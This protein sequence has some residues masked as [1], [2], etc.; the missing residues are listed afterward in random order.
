M[1]SNPN[2]PWVDPNGHALAFLKKYQPKEKNAA[3]GQR[4]P[5]DR[6]MPSQEVVHIPEVLPPAAAL[7]SVEVPEFSVAPPKI[8]MPTQ[9]LPDDLAQLEHQLRQ[10]A[11]TLNFDLPEGRLDK[12]FG[13]LNHRLEVKIERAHLTEEFQA[14][15]LRRIR[16]AA[17]EA[18]AIDQVRFKHF[19]DLLVCWRTAAEEH[20][21]A[22]YAKRTIERQQ[23]IEDAKARVEIAECE[24]RIRD[25]QREPLPPP[26]PPPPPSPVDEA[27]QKRQAAQQA[28]KHEYDVA[29]DELEEQAEFRGEKTNR[30]VHEILKVFGNPSMRKAA[31][32]A[33]ILELI[34]VFQ[35][36]ESVLP[37]GVRELLD[38]ED[39]YVDENI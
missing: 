4:E 29:L 35:I 19:L 7:P 14:I 20:Y 24:L 10:M 33:R 15:G 28:R 23:A 2:K 21:R 34:D 3:S 30:A 5:K 27:T 1:S 37:S 9:F 39:Q 11:T 25:A 18:W 36:D 13:R 6:N 12:W 31:R 38:E 26:P 16:N 17:E 22:V 32:R 8:C